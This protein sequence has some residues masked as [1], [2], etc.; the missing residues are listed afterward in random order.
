MRKC[1]IIGGGPA[2]LSCAHRLMERGEGEWLAIVLEKSGDFGGISRTVSCMSGC[3]VDVGGHRFFSKNGFV[4]EW[5]RKRFKYSSSPE[6][7]F[8]TRPR[9]SRIA[10]KNKFFDYP[11]SLS[12]STLSNLGFT[13]SAMAGM[14]FFKSCFYKRPEDSLEDFYINRFGSILYSWFFEKYTEKVWGEHPS[15]MPPDWGRQR[16]RGLSLGRALVN[17]ARKT[18][19]LSG[20]GDTSLV[21]SFFYPAKGPGQMWTKTAAEII[22]MGGLVLKNSA[23][24]RLEKKERG[25]FMVH[26]GN[27]AG[28]SPFVLDA[29]IVVSSAPLDE[30]SAMLGDLS[31]DSVSKAMRALPYRNFVIAALLLDKNVDRGDCWIYI[32][33]PGFVSGRLQIFNNWSPY[34]CHKGMLVGMEYFCSEDDDFWNMTDREI[35]NLAIKEAEKI[36]LCENREVISAHVERQPKAYPVY[37]GSWKDMNLV[38]NFLDSVP[39]LY[40]VG[41]N[42]QHR[43]NNMD[44]SMLSGFEAAD[45]ILSGVAGSPWNVN[46]EESYHEES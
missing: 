10:F 36:G 30:L 42:G 14:S 11:L 3:L 23:A 26:C 15:K 20:T 22:G 32:Q 1:V 28:N 29:D 24:I 41:R 35:I 7:V 4:N 33:E 19:G 2:G 37:G 44:H 39:G 40:C 45:R 17:A 46:E 5:W 18:V 31:P 34:L 43:Y 21:G 8:M 13:A 12:F 27:M 16:V 9:K 6:D 25:G 38:K